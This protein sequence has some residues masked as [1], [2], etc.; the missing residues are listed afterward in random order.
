MLGR[1]PWCWILICVDDMAWP[2]VSIDLLAMTFSCACTYGFQEDGVGAIVNVEVGG[3]AVATLGG[4]T[5]RAPRATDTQ[6]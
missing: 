5:P 6:P 4:N 1:S 3:P 2:L